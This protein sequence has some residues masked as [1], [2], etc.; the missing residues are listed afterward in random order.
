MENMFWLAALRPRRIVWS[1]ERAVLPVAWPDL[2]FCT[3]P[4]GSASAG[5]IVLPPSCLGAPPAGWSEKTFQDSGGETVVTPG[6]VSLRIEHAFDLLHSFRNVGFPH[7][8]LLFLA[9]PLFIFTFC[10]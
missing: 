7:P 6:L 10:E 4:Q 8:L 9:F 5:L 2:H 1:C 3:L